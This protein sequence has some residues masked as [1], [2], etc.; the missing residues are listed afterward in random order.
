MLELDHL[1]SRFLDLGFADLG[2]GDRALL[3]RLLSEQDQD[4]HHWM[5]ARSVEPPE[6]LRD[7]IAR[8][9]AVA[10]ESSD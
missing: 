7:L 2:E 9:R 6:E 8:I 1:L 4:L 10:S 5:I 3:A